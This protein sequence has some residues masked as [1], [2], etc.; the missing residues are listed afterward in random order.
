MKKAKGLILFL[1]MSMLLLI[2][3]GCGEQLQGKTKEAGELV[4]YSARKEKFV[5]P[6]L[7]A[8]EAE[9]GIKVKLLT[10]DEASVNKILE[11]MNNPQADIFFSNDTG[12]MEYLRL[13]GAL[14]PNDSKALEVIDAKFRADD[15]SWVGLSARSRVL[16]YN[17]DLITEEE[18][19]KRLEEIAD[20]KWKGQ[21][22]ITRGGNGS[23]VAHVA[24]LRAVWGDE[25]TKKWLSDIAEN[26]GAITK[27]H[28]D[29]RKAVGAGEFKFG[30]VNNYYYHQQLYE[31]KDN[32]VGVI[33]PDQDG[34][35]VFV[36]AAGVALIKGGPNMDNAKKFI[37]FLLQP[38]QMKVFAYNSKEVPLH[39]D[40]EAIPEAKKI[41]EYKIMD[42][43][44]K[45]IGP[46]WN[47]AKQLI[48]ESGL[49]LEIK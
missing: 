42:M 12:A 36:N 6:L 33:Y 34:M 32:N 17:K 18:M 48:E 25:K 28:T 2:A 14:A 16:M 38:E 15:G 8:F 11:E 43:P 35:G 3:V 39:P 4:V 24:A 29:I 19:P 30:L 44:L 31:D 1:V 10:G 37:D 40:V 5:K 46:V 7:D 47:D 20:P 26:A 23:M 21:F 27:G 13:Q 9:T 49:A 22:A 41:N 45:E